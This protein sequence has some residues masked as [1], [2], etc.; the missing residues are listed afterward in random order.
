MVFL[1]LF[2]FDAYVYFSISRYVKSY[3]NFMIP[4]LGY[5]VIQSVLIPLI[6]LAFGTL[7]VS[8]VDYEIVCALIIY[9]FS[10]LLGVKLKKDSL[11]NVFFCV[12]DVFDI[13]ILQKKSFRYA[14]LGLIALTLLIMGILSIGVVS[15]IKNPRNFYQFHREGIGA[16]Y[17]F[18]ISSV[19][20]LE[21]F[22]LY[23]LRH[24]FSKLL[25]VFICFVF[26][27]CGASKESILYA[28]FIIIYFYDEKHRL[29]FRNLILFAIIMMGLMG[30]L[31]ILHGTAGTMSDILNYFDYYANTR[32]FFEKIFNE[33][34]LF[35]GEI[36]FSSFYKY[37][38]RM[39]VGVKPKVYGAILIQEE[40]FPGLA[41][42]N[43]YPAFMG[44]VYK[45]GDFGFVELFIRAMITGMIFGI[46]YDYYKNRKSFWSII[47]YMSNFYAIFWL[48]GGW[49][50]YLYWICICVLIMAVNF[51]KYFRPMEIK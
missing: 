38:P 13:K 7:R 17:S 40:L 23:S 44:I 30:V 45:M 14:L 10:L 34:R 9:N 1:I 50:N 42:E 22:A 11:K 19:L 18:Y 43:H 12:W 33:K 15:I 3:I 27:Y 35:H 49:M 29:K 31:M 8:Y 5:Q 25:F 32:L 46:K 26:L 2:I 28:V 51:M 24:N 21:I 6:G 16:F 47:I 41:E 48:F 37:L 20:L 36:F 4:V 39:I